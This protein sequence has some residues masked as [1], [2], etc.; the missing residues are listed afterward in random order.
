MIYTYCFL[1]EIS[2]NAQ[3]KL[4]LAVIFTVLAGMVVQF[5]IS[6]YIFGK[7]LYEIWAKVE[8]ARALNFAK[9]GAQKCTQTLDL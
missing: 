3:E 2:V 6:I 7:A 9:I 5:V 4:E 8:K 1:W